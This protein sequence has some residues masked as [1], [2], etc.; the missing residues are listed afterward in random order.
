MSMTDKYLH[1]SPVPHKAAASAVIDY[2]PLHIPSP[3]IVFG[4]EIKSPHMLSHN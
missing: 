1:Q 4:N 3:V 2:L